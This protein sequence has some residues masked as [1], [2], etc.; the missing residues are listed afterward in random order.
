MTI[1]RL[2]DGDYS[3]GNGPADLI[4]GLPEIMQKCET[5][6]MQLRGEWFLNSL[7]GVDWGSVISQNESESAISD[8]IKK[9]LLTVNGVKSVSK[10][11]ITGNSREFEISVFINTEYGESTLTKT[12]NSLELLRNDAT[13]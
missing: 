13:N 11:A 7:D 9:T 3:F 10:I 4:T 1:R 12:L 2:V 8:I 6:L 5:R